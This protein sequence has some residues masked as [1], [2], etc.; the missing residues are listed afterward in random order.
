MSTITITRRNPIT[1]KIETP[2]LY[3]GGYYK[4]ANPAFGCDKKKDELEIRL[5]TC[6]EVVAHYYRGFHVRMSSGP[7]GGRPSLI[8]PASL[9]ISTG[10]QE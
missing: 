1:G 5:R 7:G 6:A 10:V 3:K 9:N 4:V 2:H 8:S